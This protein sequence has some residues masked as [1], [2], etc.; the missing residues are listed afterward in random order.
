MLVGDMLA[1]MSKLSK[2]YSKNKQSNLQHFTYKWRE[3]A[4]RAKIE[5]DV[6][7]VDCI[8]TKIDHILSELVD[9]G[10]KAEE[11]SDHWRSLIERNLNSLCY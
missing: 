7:L 4:Y 8:R 11:F 2:I 6:F 3:S 5:E 9:F 10:E 1:K